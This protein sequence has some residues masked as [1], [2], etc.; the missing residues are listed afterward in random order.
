MAFGA[1]CIP[2]CLCEEKANAARASGN[3]YV[4]TE[5]EFCQMVCTYDQCTMGGQCHRECL[6]RLEEGLMRAWVTSRKKH[7]SVTFASSVEGLWQ[8]EEIYTKVRS[9]CRCACGKGYFR[10]AGTGTKAKGVDDEAL[11][12]KAKLEEELAKKAERERERRAAEKAERAKAIEEARARKAAEKEER[13]AAARQR[14]AGR[15]AL[16]GLNEAASPFAVGADG[17]AWAAATAQAKALASPATRGLENDDQG[18][19]R[20]RTPRPT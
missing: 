10:K 8:H 5:T 1:C 12:R 18:H 19:P 6:D 17:S 14:A 16:A 2:N 15:A 9:L 7:Q 13:A 4:R 11:E 20:S 3:A